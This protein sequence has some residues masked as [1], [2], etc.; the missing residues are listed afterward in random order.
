MTT[1]TVTEMPPKLEPVTRDTFVDGLAGLALI[2]PAKPA[3][4]ASTPY[5]SR[6]ELQFDIQRDRKEVIR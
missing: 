4:D 6:T 2:T 1:P 5:E 3:R